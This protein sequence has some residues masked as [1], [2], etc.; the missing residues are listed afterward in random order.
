VQL[1]SSSSIHNNSICSSNQQHHDDHH[2]DDHHHVPDLI[3]GRL[4]LLC[5]SSRLCRILSL[6]PPCLTTTTS[7]CLKTEKQDE[8]AE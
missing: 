3:A 7:F 6:R 4:L 2:D 5:R 1:P 8:E